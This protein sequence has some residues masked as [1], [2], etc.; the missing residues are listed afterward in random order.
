MRNALSC[1]CVYL[2]LC[3]Y[4]HGDSQ[5]WLSISVRISSALVPRKCSRFCG[6]TRLQSQWRL[7]I[8]KRTHTV[9]I[10]RYHWPDARNMLRTTPTKKYIFPHGN[11]V[12]TIYLRLWN[13]FALQTPTS[14]CLRVKSIDDWRKSGG[15]DVS[16]GE[17][18]RRRWQPEKIHLI[19]S[20]N[21]ASIWFES[22]IRISFSPFCR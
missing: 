22:I 10:K 6:L 7:Q 11:K 5:Q 1:V 13:C 14:A 4:S 9:C 8:H 16:G 12:C 20:E 17:R 19:T 21:I 18:R 3:K 2:C 15:G